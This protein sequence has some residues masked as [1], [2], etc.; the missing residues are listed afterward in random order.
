MNN[1]IFSHKVAQT[2]ARDIRDENRV[3]QYKLYNFVYFI[4]NQNFIHIGNNYN[5]SD[6]IVIHI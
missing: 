5:C 4:E 3:I 6:T 2:W 1:T